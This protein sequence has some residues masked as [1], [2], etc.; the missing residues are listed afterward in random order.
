[1]HNLTNMKHLCLVIGLLFVIGTINAQ[2][3]FAN[4]SFDGPERYTPKTKVKTAAEFRAMKDRIRAF[5]SRLDYRYDYLNELSNSED[6]NR[7]TDEVVALVSF[8]YDTQHR[9]I[10][11]NQFDAIGDDAEAFLLSSVQ[12]YV[13][14]LYMTND[15]ANY[16]LINRISDA[17]LED[18]PG[19]RDFL[20]YPAMTSAAVGNYE[21]ALIYLH[22]AE[23]LHREDGTVAILL[24]DNYMQLKNTN[25]ALSYYKKAVRY[26]SESEVI[27]AKKA[28]EKIEDTE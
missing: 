6:W 7:L 19:H 9:W 28:I 17:V 1:M 11:N 13:L 23:N 2:T 14:M 25:L 21:K 26:G 3:S 20:T 4:I 10:W 18:N 16:N 22:K 27:A 15:V 8:S 12:D 5:P 24:G